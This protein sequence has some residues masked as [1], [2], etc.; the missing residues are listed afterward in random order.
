LVFGKTDFAWTI[1]I[2]RV[3][4]ALG[5]RS[6]VLGENGF[7]FRGVQIFGWANGGFDFSGSFHTER[8]FCIPKVVKNHLYLNVILRVKMYYIIFNKY[9]PHIFYS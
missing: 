6:F 8:L 9:A 2:S 7:W 5:K 4:I 1:L 3:E